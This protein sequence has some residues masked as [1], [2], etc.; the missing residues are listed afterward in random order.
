M[1]SPAGSSV[2]GFRLI[3]AAVLQ[4]RRPERHHLGKDDLADH[5]V[6]LEFFEPDLRVPFTAARR[7]GAL[8]I[9]EHPANH[10]VR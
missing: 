4:Q 9:F 10:V 5:A 1:A 2:A 8:A 6:R 3:V 7:E